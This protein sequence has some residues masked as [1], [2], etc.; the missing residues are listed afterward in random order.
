[1]GQ[2]DA[3]AG[4]PVRQSARGL[5]PVSGAGVTVGLEAI[6]RHDMPGFLLNTADDIAAVLAE[7]GQ[8]AGLDAQID[9]YHMAREGVDLSALLRQPPAP[10]GH[11]Q[12]ADVPAVARRAPASWIGPRCLPWS[13]SIAPR[14]GA[15]RNI[16]RPAP[17]RR[18][19]RCGRLG[20]AGTRALRRFG[21]V[22]GLS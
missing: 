1:M 20:G 11:V 13:S 19:R 7:L 6:N 9:L 21:G 22:A 17:I 10:I 15:R 2:P 16:A 3:G 8:P 12:F 18:S 4:H 5:A 14:C